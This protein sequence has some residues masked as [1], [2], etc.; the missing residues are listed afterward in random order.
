MGVSPFEQLLTGLF[1]AAYLVAY[2]SVLVWVYRDATR[3]ETSPWAV[4]LL[5]TILPIWPIGLGLWLLSRPPATNYSPI[6][7]DRLNDLSYPD[8]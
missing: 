7:R 6:D 8:R 1:I 5:V 3:R 4:L 2:L